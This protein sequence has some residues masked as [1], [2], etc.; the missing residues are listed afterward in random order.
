MDYRDHR[1]DLNARIFNLVTMG[2]GLRMS[3]R[4]VG[5]SQRCGELKLRK[6]ARHLRQLNLNLRHPMK[7]PVELQFDELETFEGNRSLRPLSVPML[8]EKETRYCIWA[9]SASIRP[10]GKMTKKRLEKIAIEQKKRG[11]R[12][13][14]SRRAIERTLARGRE[15]IAEHAQVVFYTDEKSTYPGL[16]K[17]AFGAARLTHHKT[18]SKLPR[19]TQNPLFPINHEDARIRD[20]VGRLRRQS[21]LASQRSRFLDLALQMHMAYRNLVRTRFNYDDQ[22]PAQMLGFVHRRLTIHELL[23]WSQ[24]WGKR[25][26][27]PLSRRGNSVAKYQE[28]L[29]AAA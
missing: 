6:I 7:G 1:P 2:V 25:S 3:A 24:R 27:H 8:I 19:T 20:M 17:A 15:L 13:D 5:I 21:W 29:L 16:A 10:R 4:R 22:S 14:R 23:S 11:R 9:E 28:A 26:L 12:K 18:N